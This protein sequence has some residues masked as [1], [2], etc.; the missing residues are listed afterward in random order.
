MV[1]PAAPAAA[2]AAAAASVDSDC[3]GSAILACQSCL[4]AFITTTTS[5]SSSSSRQ[6]PSSLQ[7]LQQQLLGHTFLHPSL[8]QQAL[9]H[10]SHTGGPNYQRVEFLGDSVLDLHVSSWL[11]VELSQHL[12]AQGAGR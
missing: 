3:A 12:Q 5:D 7:Q 8:L 11:M 4:N 1:L 10:V 2:A 6:L 9:T